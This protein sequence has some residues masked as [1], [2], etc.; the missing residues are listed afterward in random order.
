MRPLILWGG[1]ALLYGAFLAWYSG[2]G[3]PLTPEEV[4]HFMEIA[5]TGSR[6]E[7]QLGDL[8]RFLESD[9]GEPFIM[10]NSIQLNEGPL[11]DGSTASEAIDRYMA[12]MWPALLKRACHPVIAGGAVGP[13][14]DVWGIEGAEDWSQAGLIRYRSRRDLME[15]ATNPEFSDSHH[16]KI[17]AMKKTVAFPVETLVNLGDPR[18][19]L[20]LLLFSLCAG[21]RLLQL[22]RR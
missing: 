19:V 11:P 4:D 1:A 18:P 14:L 16:F 20:G 21:V 13:A 3:G 12:Y 2:F 5:S 9:T 8:R 10:V 7:G 17:D 6:D 22:R 15:I